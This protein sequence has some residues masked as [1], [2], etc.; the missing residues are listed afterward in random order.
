MIQVL[1]Q[2]LQQNQ[3]VFSDFCCSVTASRLLMKKTEEHLSYFASS[4]LSFC[5]GIESGIEYHS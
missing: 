4:G 2:V 1:I 3:P 5:C